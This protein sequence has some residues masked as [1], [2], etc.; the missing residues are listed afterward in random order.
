MCTGMH[1]YVYYKIN[2]CRCIQINHTIWICLKCWE[3]PLNPVVCHHFPY[4]TLAS[5]GSPVYKFAGTPVLWMLLKHP[6]SSDLSRPADFW[7]VCRLSLAMKP[8]SISLQ[9]GSA[10]RE[11]ANLSKAQ[12]R[13]VHVCDRGPNFFWSAG[14]EVSSRVSRVQKNGVEAYF[15]ML[16]LQIQCPS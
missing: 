9:I 4:Q 16:L 3:K 7:I 14:W 13:I 2:I 12:I 8:P 15:D 10:A 6:E 11:V 1:M 5:G